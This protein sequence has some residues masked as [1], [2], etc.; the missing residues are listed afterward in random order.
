M[1]R[2][3]GWALGL[4]GVLFFFGCGVP[5][6]VAGHPKASLYVLAGPVELLP[7]GGQSWQPATSCF[8]LDQGHAVRTGSS[9]EALV[10][11]AGG[12]KLFLDTGSQ[13]ALQTLA[14]VDPGQSTPLYRVSLQGGTYLDAPGQGG[15]L[16]LVASPSAVVA[17]Y[18]GTVWLQYD[19]S[20]GVVSLDLVQGKALLAQVADT[21]T[22]VLRVVESVPRASVAIS[23]NGAPSSAGQ[24]LLQAVTI[25]LAA[26]PDAFS[27]LSAAGSLEAALRQLA[28]EAAQNPTLASRLSALGLAVPASPTLPSHDL[29]LLTLQGASPEAWPALLASS[30]AWAGVELEPLELPTAPALIQQVEELPPE[31]TPPGQREQTGRPGE[32]PPCGRDAARPPA[33][34]GPSAQP[35]GSG[36]PAAGG[37]GAAGRGAAVVLQRP[38]RSP[39]AEERARGVERAA[40][41]RG[42]G[43]EGAQAAGTRGERP[44]QAGGREPGRPAETGQRGQERPETGRGPE[45]APGQE[46]RQGR[47][48][49]GR[50]QEQ[51]AGQ[52]QGEGGPGA[53]E[54]RER[55]QERPEGSQGPGGP[56]GQEGQEGGREP[57]SGAGSQERETPGGGQG[58]PEEPA[59]RGGPQERGSRAGEATPTVLPQGRTPTPTS[60]PA[61]TPTPTP[62]PG[63]GGGAPAGGSAQAGGGGPPRTPTP[64]P[65]SAPI[66]TPAPA[67][68]AATPTP[69]PTA[70]PTPTPT[71][72]AMPTPT[73]TPTPTPTPKPTPPGQGGGGQGGGNR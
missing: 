18:G 32:R 5:A 40:Q 70:T 34:G 59:E 22:P 25:L 69:A 4:A 21:G 62:R 45:G 55:G 24:Q 19:G 73:R 13:L 16:V 35:P 60:V 36:G 44:E 9:G 11:L 14:Y 51:A 58:R 63:Q 72:T 67:A 12:G 53:Q 57:A 64:T 6:L 39:Q 23:G 1:S 46:A 30:P 3:G 29:G 26:G 31:G 56:P 17:V 15:G 47:E 38:P 2:K 33:R 43:G 28:Q 54:N 68:P 50:G 10:S 52:G 42:R 66:P 7:S 65:T 37:P 49:E 20:S 41:A 61:P 71:P 8:A 27:R 48:P